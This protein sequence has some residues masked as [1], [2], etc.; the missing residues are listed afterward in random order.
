MVLFSSW[1]NK[2]IQF[3]LFG[4]LIFLIYSYID[5]FLWKLITT[6]LAVIIIPAGT[7]FVMNSLRKARE[8]VISPD[9]NINIYVQSLVKIYERENRWAR[10]WKAGARIRKR[11]GLEKKYTSWKDVSQITWQ[12]PLLGF[13]I[14]FTYFYLNKGFWIFIFSIG[15]WF[16]LSGIWTTFNELFTN[17]AKKRRKKMANESNRNFRFCHFLDNSP[18][19]PYLVPD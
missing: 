8:T 3:L 12:V 4:L 19:E 14:Y 5:K 7:W 16:F 2:I 11:L 6:I 15:T 10:E 18:S 9:E 1:K 17:L 13:I